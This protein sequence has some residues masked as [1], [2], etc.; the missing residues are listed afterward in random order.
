M[1]PIKIE[2]MKI[3]VSNDHTK[4]YYFKTENQTASHI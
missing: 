4:K 2:I 1:E 3:V